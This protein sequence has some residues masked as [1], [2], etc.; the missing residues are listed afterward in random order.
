MNTYNLVKDEAMINAL[1]S[2]KRVD[3]KGYLYKMDVNYDYY[4]LLNQ[5]KL[6]LE[7][8]CSSF[9]TKNDRGE[10]IF[11]R[12]YDFSHFK[13]NDRH[14]PRTGINL[15]V[16]LKNPNAKYKSIGVADAFWLDFKNGN[17]IEG[18]ADDGV[19]DISP[20]ILCPFICMD[21]VN[22]K[23]IAVSVMQLNVKT[24]WEEIEYE[25]CRE[26]IEYGID[27]YILGMPNEIPSEDYIYSRE[28][29]IAINEA[30][31]KAWIAHVDMWETKMPNK[32][33][34][35]IPPVLMRFILDN[36]ATIEEAIALADLYNISGATPGCAYHIMIV[37]SLGNSKLLEWVNDRMN[38]VDIDHV[39]N[40]Y[41]TKDDGYHGICK[42][43]EC[44]KAGLF[45][46]K[47][48]GM[49]ED[50]AES[51]L[52]LISQDASTNNDI[53]KT[54]YSCIYNTKTKDLRVYAFGYFKK[55]YDFNLE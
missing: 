44:I 26:K 33:G 28:G 6:I 10:Y 5:I 38:V 46:T 54:Q 49:R 27:P 18:Y 42:R 3:D 22:E 17:I 15:V 41:V 19:S 9:Y 37:D 30:D 25:G 20:F 48:G 24:K 2:I 16:K 51:L 50:Y 32:K 8:G 47:N 4:P 12:N 29:K 53:G 35:L 7:A 21:G 43:D 1:K 40:H 23:G 31:K 39:T 52:K 36:C 13:N 11:C 34:T 14:N 45:R 55:Y